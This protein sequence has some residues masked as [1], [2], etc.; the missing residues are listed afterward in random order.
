MIEMSPQRWQSS[1]DYVRAVFAAERGGLN[2]LASRAAAAGLPDIA[3]TPETGRFLMI[4]AATSGGGRGARRAL[5]I[6]TLGGYSALWIARGLAADGRLITLE[7]EPAHAAFAAREFAAAGERRIELR[8]ARA[9][10]EFP[11]L[12]AEFGP[13]SFDFVFADAIKTEYEA[14]FEWARVH[15]RPG[16]VFAAHNALGSNTWWIDEAA[17]EAARAQRDAIDR[18]NRGVAGDPDFDAVVLPLP[19]GLLVARRRHA[20]DV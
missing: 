6:G 9:L 8:R 13:E 10:D 18:F 15:L 7:P 3:V 11:R 20:P 16:G 17:D 1:L 2:G 4:L 19:Q 14:Y 12:A 5:E